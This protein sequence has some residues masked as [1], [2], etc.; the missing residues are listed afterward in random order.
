MYSHIQGH[1]TWTGSPMAAKSQSELEQTIEYIKTNLGSF[2]RAERE[3][4]LE[5]LQNYNVTKARDNFYLN[6]TRMNS[7]YVQT[8]CVACSH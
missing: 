8:D 2:S 5:V 1:N 6:S 3:K 7:T 4:A